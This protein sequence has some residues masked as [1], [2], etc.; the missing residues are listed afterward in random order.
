MK[1]KHLRK[2]CSAFPDTTVFFLFSLFFSLGGVSFFEAGCG[3]KEN[4]MCLSVCSRTSL[5]RDILTF[6]SWLLRI[7]RREPD[8]FMEILM[9]CVLYVY[10]PYK[11]GGFPAN[12]EMANS[13]VASYWLSRFRTLSSMLNILVIGTVSPS[14]PVTRTLHQ[15]F[16]NVSTVSRDTFSDETTHCRP[17]GMQEKKMT[18]VALKLPEKLR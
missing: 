11:G 4:W 2:I 17:A 8:Y 5:F 10:L 15:P 13:L 1:S 14:G 12:M 3:H 18:H 7:E 9:K 6:S 16:N